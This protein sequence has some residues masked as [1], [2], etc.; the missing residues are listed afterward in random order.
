MHGQTN[1]AVVIAERF[2]PGESLPGLQS[3]SIGIAADGKFNDV[4]SAEPVDQ[5]GR[6]TFSDY[7]TVIDDSQTIAETLS[8]VH[9]VRS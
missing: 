2:D 9:V 5:I 1:E 6:G 8:F 7:L 3:G 4:M